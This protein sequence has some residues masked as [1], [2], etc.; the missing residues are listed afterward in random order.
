MGAAIGDILGLA[1]G[2]AGQPLADCGHH[3][4]AGHPAGQDNGVLFAVGW[5]AGL[6]VLGT[7]VLLL[8]GPADASTDG[9]PAA[10]TGRL[11]L[12]LGALILA[13]AVRQWRSRPAEGLSRRCRDGWPAWTGGGQGP[14]HHGDR[15]HH[16]KQ[17][18]QRLAQPYD[19]PRCD[20]PGW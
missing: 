1:A 3:S 12:V 9:E 11:K 5:L 17:Q 8:T 6:A 18:R 15:H 10:W 20:R 7:A 2:V 14:A 19:P 4:D 13:L 16:Q